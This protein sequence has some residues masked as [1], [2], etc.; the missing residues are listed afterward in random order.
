MGTDKTRKHFDLIRFKPKF[1]S[2]TP[3]RI[4]RITRMQKDAVCIV[5]FFGVVTEA[6]PEFRSEFTEL[7][8][9]GGPHSVNSGLGLCALCGQRLSSEEVKMT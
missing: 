9:L 5:I 4:T 8:R 7:G 2:S 3:P 6:E 1:G